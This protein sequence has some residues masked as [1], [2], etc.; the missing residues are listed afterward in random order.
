ML[1][2]RI[3][4]SFTSRT[5]TGTSTLKASSPGKFMGA[6]KPETLTTALPHPSEGQRR[7]CPGTS[8]AASIQEKQNW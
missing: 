7:C 6:A 1:S 4:P 2:N 3:L 5:T 8:S